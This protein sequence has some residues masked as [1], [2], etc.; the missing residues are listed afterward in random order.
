MSIESIATVPAVGSS[1]PS[2]TLMVVVLPAPLG[3]SSPTISPRPTVNET[4]SSAVTPAYRLQRPATRNAGCGLAVL[5]IGV[6]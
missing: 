2:I 6:K 4:S 3:P 5:G 1:T